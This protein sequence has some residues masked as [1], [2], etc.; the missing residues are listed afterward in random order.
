MVFSACG[1]LHSN[2]DRSAE[3]RP[4]ASDSVTGKSQL[5]VS[6]FR[7]TT[8][9]A[10]RQPYTTVRT[11]LAVFWH[12]PKEIVSGNLPVR[13]DLTPPPVEVPG[14]EEFE[15][16]LD[17]QG[18]PNRESGRLTWLVDGREF[19]PELDRRLAAA[20]ERVDLQ[21]FIYDNDDVAVQ[22]AD[23]LKAKAETVPVRV[24]FDDLGSSF[25]HTAA[26]ETPGPRGFVPPADMAVYLK[27]DS[28]IQVRRSLNPWLVCDHT[29]L[30]VFDR[31]T[32]IM[33]GMNM[34]REYYSEWHDVM[35]KVEGPIVGR[36]QGEFSRAWRKA[37]PW[38]DLA[39]FQRPR[40]FRKPEPVDGG[41]PLRLLR[42]DAA[43]GQEQILK[44]T[45]LGIRAAKK[46]IWIENPY[47]AHDDIAIEVEAAAR[48]GVDVRVILPARGD[49]TIMD[50][51]NLGT[52]RGLIEAGAKV[53][54]YP[55]MTHMKVIICDGWAQVGSANLDI[56]SMRI[57]REMNLAFSDP[58]TVRDLERKVFLPDFRASKL[59]RHEE[60]TSPVAPIAEAVADQL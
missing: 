48:R 7:A 52:A 46:R 19:F 38:G 50:A 26:P 12:R 31:R 39:M 33:G 11:G 20:K 30:L 45:L 43:A 51:G 59:V 28:R 27:N 21:F 13:L 47:F 49:S 3:R 34:G 40:F 60:T 15:M 17:R 22:Y 23:R 2:A 5:A 44:S 1:S 55:R 16:L 4:Q 37:G 10:V 32:A 35:V 42:T 6:A 57:N 54:R 24:L 41:V 25:A 14:S 53:Y 58:A 18:M 9:A 29:K 8:L 36:L 56:L